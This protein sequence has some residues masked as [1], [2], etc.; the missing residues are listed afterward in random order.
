MGD[1][2]PSVAGVTPFYFSSFILGILDY[3]FA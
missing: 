2:P 1:C 3:M